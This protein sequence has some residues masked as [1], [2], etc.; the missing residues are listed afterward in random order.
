MKNIPLGYVECDF[1]EAELVTSDR[2]ERY[3][4]AS[5][6]IAH[7]GAGMRCVKKAGDP[8]EGYVECQGGLDAHSFDGVT[9]FEGYAANAARTAAKLPEGYHLHE[10]DLY[11][12]DLVLTGPEWKP[13]RSRERNPEFIYCRRNPPIGYEFCGQGARIEGDMYL[14][15]Q[16]REWVESLNTQRGRNLIY[17]TLIR[18]DLACLAQKLVEYTDTIN[19]TIQHRVKLRAEIRDQMESDLV[20]VDDGD[21][22]LVLTRS[23]DGEI[24]V[25]RA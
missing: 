1:E 22:H 2:N 11:R 19:S 5:A 21:S 18:E 6:S 10:G 15:P 23:S 25:R 7:T 17:V 8:L 24:D 12:D 20:V 4:Y 3:G 13:C 14:C 16:S 9:W